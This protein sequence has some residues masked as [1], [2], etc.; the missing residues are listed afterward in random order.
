MA[1]RRS[2]ATPKPSFKEMS[3]SFACGGY[4]MMYLFGVAKALQEFE[5]KKDARLVGCSAGAL[6]ATGLALH[7]DFDAIRDHVLH[8]VV[9]LGTPVTVLLAGFILNW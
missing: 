5:L 7:C 4:L 1:R 2:H 8:N 3:F 9:P 6:T